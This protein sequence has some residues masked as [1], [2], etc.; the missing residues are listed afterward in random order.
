L[1]AAIYKF[2]FGVAALLKEVP[3]DRFMPAKLSEFARSRRIAMVAIYKFEKPIR[4]LNRSSRD[5]VNGQFE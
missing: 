2:H 5:A 1:L 4:D 3:R